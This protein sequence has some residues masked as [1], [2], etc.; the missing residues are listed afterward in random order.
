MVTFN[1]TS[2]KP[3]SER[4]KKALAARTGAVQDSS[5][6]TR[7][8]T[9]GGK[10]FSVPSNATDEYIRMKQAN[11]RSKDT[12]GGKNIYSEDQMNK[13]L[14]STDLPEEEVSIEQPTPGDVPV[15]P[16]NL[17]PT[18]PSQASGI[19]M[20]TKFSKPADMNLVNQYRKQFETGSLA[21][22]YKQGLATANQSGTPAPQSEGAARTQMQ[23]Y[24][25]TPEVNTGAVDTLLQEDEGWQQ[26]QQMK[27]DYFDPKN[28]KI[29]LVDEYKK[30]YKNSGLNELDE[31]ILDAK[32]IIEGTEDDIRN[33]IQAAGGFGTDSQV[34]ALA[35]SRNKVLLKNY[36]NLVAMREMKQQNFDTM[37]SL[38]DKDRQYADQQFDRMT[39][40]EMQVMN[41]KQK[42]V[43]NT[44]SQLNNIAD[45]L[46]YQALYN[47][48]SSDPRQL[49]FAE[50]ILGV[51]TGGLQKLAS[52]FDLDRE[53]KRAQIANIYSE[54]N[55]RALDNATPTQNDKVGNIASLGIDI[56][57][58]NAV[59]KGSAI[60]FSAAKLLPF[61]RALGLQGDRVAFENKVESLKSNLTLENLKLLKGAMSDKDLAFIQSVGSSL[62]TDM[63]PREF[64]KEV[65]RIVNKISP[66]SLSA[67]GYTLSPEGDVIQIID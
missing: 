36:N 46:G 21:D 2:Y 49:A 53:M 13:S 31:E 25:R 29:S 44:R 32:T 58:P 63:S 28:Q 8:V 41:Y 34:Q 15:G 35:S 55:K 19:P 64:D 33:E 62:S 40:F 9:V 6:G 10:R 14:G 5:I 59:G 24:T 20:D 11:L 4:G 61:G 22:Q 39:N 65:Y 50:K 43:D 26:L 18:I 16:Q 60:G 54:I 27:K 52:Q 38:A 45:K 37:L 23:S 56:L 67:S 48:Y 57:S 66:E 47:A 17:Q 7:R 3:Q 30:L 12:R 51:G 42:F 1:N